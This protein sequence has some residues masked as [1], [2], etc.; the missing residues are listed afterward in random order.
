MRPTFGIES[1]NSHLQESLYLQYPHVGPMPSLFAEPWSSPITRAKQLIPVWKRF[2]ENRRFC[3]VTWWIQKWCR[4]KAMDMP[5][6]HGD[7]FYA[8]ED[9]IFKSV[10]SGVVG[11]D[12]VVDHLKPAIDEIVASGVHKGMYWYFEWEEH[13]LTG[14]RK[15]ELLWRILNDSICLARIGFPQDILNQIGKEQ[16]FQ[17]LSFKHPESWSAESKAVR[18]IF[19]RY[20]TSL[21]MDAAR[22]IL[23]KAYSRCGGFFLSNVS[24]VTG[25]VDQ[26]GHEYDAINMLPNQLPC[27]YMHHTPEHQTPQ[28]RFSDVIASK[29]AAKCKVLVPNLDC[30]YLNEQTLASRSLLCA[31]G[32]APTVLFASDMD[33][34]PHMKA[35]LVRVFEE[36]L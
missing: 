27:V 10:Q 5:K 9:D 8:S 25:M 14:P 2:D 28:V 36:T 26:H 19:N 29:Y 17:M 22:R 20:G 30:V 7:D 32:G 1:T 23:G 24:N 15:D 35:K 33:G 3:K 31:K 13:F 16:V 34:M 11:C 4:T 18:S 6:P 21:A 12:A